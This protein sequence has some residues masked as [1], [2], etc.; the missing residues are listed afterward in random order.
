MA[1]MSVFAFQEANDHIPTAQEIAESLAKLLGS[2]SLHESRVAVTNIT[3]L[4][5][6]NKDTSEK[7]FAFNVFYGNKGSIAATDVARSVMVFPSGTMLDSGQ[8]SVNQDTVLVDVMAIKRDKTI[9]E[10]S[11][12]APDNFFSVPD[13]DYIKDMASYAEAAKQWKMRIYLFIAF[14]SRDADLPPNNLRFWNGSKMLIFTWAAQ[15]TLVGQTKL[16]ESCMFHPFS[17]SAGL[18]FGPVEFPLGTEP[19][20]NERRKLETSLQLDFGNSWEVRRERSS[21]RW[22]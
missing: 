6:I 7:G 3:G 17:Q 11:P 19:C 14:R 18:A 2:Q 4:P 13:P 21:L 22:T 9:N 12:N 20:W 10:V 16:I 5:L 15:R 8:E 1:L